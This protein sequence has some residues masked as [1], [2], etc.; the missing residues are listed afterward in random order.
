[1][2]DL[3][4]DNDKLVQALL[5]ERDELFQELSRLRKIDNGTLDTLEAQNQKLSSEVV[6][7]DQEIKKLTD[8]LAWFRH[9]F[10][11][12]S[13]EKFIKE[14][15][16]QR[17]L[18]FDGIDALPQEKI[19]IE[20][21]EMELIEYERR[22]VV[23]EKKSA[24]RLPLPEHLRREIEV[25]EPEDL[26]A[27]WVRIGIEATEI[28]EFKPGEL[29]VRRIERP[30][31]A[32]KPIAARAQ[33]QSEQEEAPAV[34]IAPMPLLPLPRSNAGAS[35][36]AELLMNKY[37]YH[38]PF[39]R[40]IAM[41]KMVDVKLP[42]S[43]VNGWFQGGSD[44]LRALYLRLKDLVLESDYIQVDESTI[45]VVDNEKHKATKAYLWMVRSVM[46]NLVFFHYDKG[47]RAQKVVVDLLKHFQGAVQT[48]GYQAYSIYEQK[49]GV[50]LLGCWAHARRKFTE[51]FLEDKNGAEYALAQIAKLYQVEQMANDES[52]TYEQR[53]ELRKR[54]A[55]PI[56]RGFEKWIVAYHP[57]AIPGGR[58]S[59]AL[60][61][62]Y[63]LFERLSRYH[64]DGRYLPD[65]NLAENAIRPLAVGR[66]G[67]LF[68]GNHESAENAAIMYSLL[69]CCKACDVNPREWLTDV[70]SKIAL[71]NNNYELDLADLLPH[72]WKLSNKC[73]NFPKDSN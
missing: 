59:K 47:S 28:L 41:L 21:A 33:D 44:L 30:K 35:L 38:L 56:M 43:T 61:Y 68:C 52:M 32:V 13:S 24:V 64:L 3:S 12:K 60:S 54:L 16:N 73:Q 29:Y 6:Q 69:G 51:S 15:P 63:N 50:L 45:P 49:K 1:M 46:N 72:N 37:F 20:K 8:Q 62:T 65:N 25:I 19:A 18:D 57:K 5:Q 53:S 42:A 70:F 23:R 34:R 66:K 36:L 9:K 22:K 71:Y 39:H 31:Y 7:K 40:Q 67:F 2:S 27:N 4:S 26:R 14:D 58:M 48:D 17:K 11:S 10:F 55:Y